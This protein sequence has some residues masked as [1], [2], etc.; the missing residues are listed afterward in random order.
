MSLSDSIPG[1]VG[2]GPTCILADLATLS[3]DIYDVPDEPGEACNVRP[4]SVHL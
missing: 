2:K 3:F 1:G 4:A